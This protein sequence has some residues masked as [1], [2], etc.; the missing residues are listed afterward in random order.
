MNVIVYL[1]ND[2]KAFS[3]T[4]E[5]INFIRNR[6]PQWNIIR[7]TDENAFLDHLGKADL[8]SPG[9][10]RHNGTTRHQSLRPYLLLPQDM[11]GLK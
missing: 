2:V 3:V 11:T 1:E 9:N 5:N 7:V 6:F 10:L 4:D 8:L